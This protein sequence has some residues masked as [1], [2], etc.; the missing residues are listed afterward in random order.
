ML[1][2]WQ[3]IYRRDEGEGGW[4]FGLS[5]ALWCVSLLLLA[6]AKKEG[7]LFIGIMSV[8]D[9]VQYW[10]D[11]TRGG[12][13]HI[14]WATSSTVALVAAIGVFGLLEALSRHSVDIGMPAFDV[15][16][17]SRL[18]SPFLKAAI[19]PKFFGIAGLAFAV[20][21]VL[22][23]KCKDG[24]L[25]LFSVIVTGYLVLYV[26]HAR[27]YWF[28][29]GQEVQPIEMVR[30]LYS[31]TPLVCLVAGGVISNCVARAGEHW[32]RDKTAI[33]EWAAVLLIVLGVGVAQV[34]AVATMDD[35]AS[36]EDLAWRGFLKTVASRQNDVFVSSR[37]VALQAYVGASVE[38]VDVVALGD[39]RLRPWL[40][41]LKSEGRITLLDDGHCGSAIARDRWPQGC[42]MVKWLAE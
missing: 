41:Q 24:N 13:R 8:R 6:L 23:R 25:V 33:I 31:L 26:V 40:T 28:A 15:H 10:R 38:L 21:V 3:T 35:I 42:A 32:R 16:Y 39:P 19:T 11:R 36:Q 30:Y 7:V 5:L 14:A 1:C 34:T 22:M 17:M 27:H 12:A 20:S 2:I 37:I 9:A 18:G 29:L 4:S